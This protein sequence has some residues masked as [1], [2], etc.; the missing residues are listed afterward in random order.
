MKESKSKLKEKA[1][2][3]L[4]Q[5]GCLSMAQRY[6]AFEIEFMLVDFSLEQI[7]TSVG[8]YSVFCN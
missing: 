1:H 5:K 6:T 4:I 2:E 8:N 3:Y 7:S